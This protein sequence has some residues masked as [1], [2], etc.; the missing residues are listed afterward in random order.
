[1]SFVPISVLPLSVISCPVSE[2]LDDEYDAGN[3]ESVITSFIWGSPDPENGPVMLLIPSVTVCK[4]LRVSWV[5]VYEYGQECYCENDYYHVLDPVVHRRPP[6][7]IAV[8]L[9]P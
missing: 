9:L 6:S 3:V 4:A 2:E 7:L 8:S 1:M 5:D